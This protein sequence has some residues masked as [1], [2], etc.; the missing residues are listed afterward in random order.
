MKIHIHVQEIRVTSCT[1]LIEDHATNLLNTVK[2]V[3]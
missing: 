3:L 2:P 1:S